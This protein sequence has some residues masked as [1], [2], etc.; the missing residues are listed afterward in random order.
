MFC[1]VK[2]GGMFQFMM[3]MYVVNG[4]LGVVDMAGLG[5]FLVKGLFL[6]FFRFPILSFFGVFCPVLEVFCRVWESF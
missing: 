6:G 2:Y 4:V 3:N 1:L 5:W